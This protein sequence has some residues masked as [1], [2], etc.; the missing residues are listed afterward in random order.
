MWGAPIAYSDAHLQQEA[1]SVD[2]DGGI[3]SAAG[4]IAYTPEI[5]QWTKSHS[6]RFDA[7]AGRYANGVLTEEEAVE[8]HRL[9]AAR[10]VLVTP[11]NVDEVLRAISRKRITSEL[12]ETLRRY[13]KWHESENSAEPEA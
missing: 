3:Q 5:E 10:R 9:K 11:A 4:Q 8:L 12:L 13:A 2:L 6:R 7:L 1:G